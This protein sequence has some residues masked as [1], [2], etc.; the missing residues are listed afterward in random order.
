M[1]TRL[2]LYTSQSTP[3]KPRQEVVLGC[4]GSSLLI[5]RITILIICELL[6]SK[7]VNLI[8]PSLHKLLLRKW[9]NSQL[10]RSRHQKITREYSRRFPINEQLARSFWAVGNSFDKPIE[11]NSIKSLMQWNEATNRTSWW[12]DMCGHD[13]RVDRKPDPHF[14]S[15]ASG[16]CFD[17]DRRFSGVEKSFGHSSV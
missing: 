17:V 12:I 2:R 13:R 3:Y 8:V 15:T 5:F 9:H 10:G 14:T 6:K 16:F 7:K 1:Q 11:P 4:K